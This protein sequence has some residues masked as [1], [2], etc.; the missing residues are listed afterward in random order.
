MKSWSEINLIILTLS[1]LGAI[2][3]ISSM[4]IM[5]GEFFSASSKAV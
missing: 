1:L 5:A 4:K 3:S 2:A